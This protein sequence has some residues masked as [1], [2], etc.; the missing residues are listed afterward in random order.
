MLPLVVVN[1]A[2][3]ASPDVKIGLVPFSEYVY[4]DISTT[5]IRGVHPDKHGNTVTACLNNRR[6]PYTNED[7]TPFPYI[8]DSKWSAPGMESFWTTSGAIK[9]NASVNGQVVDCADLV[10]TE[11]AKCDTTESAAKDQCDI[12]EKA[13]KNDCEIRFSDKDDIEDCQDVAKAVANQCEDTAE[14]NEDQCVINARALKGLDQCIKPTQRSG[15]VKTEITQSDF[16]N[17]DVQCSIY[18]DRSIKVTPLTADRGVLIKQLQAMT[19]VK[20]TN[21]ALG[22][23]FGWHLVSSNEPYIDG[24]SYAAKDKKKIVVLLT[25]GKQTVG[26]YGPGN[27]FNIQKANENTASLCQSMKAKE[28]T[29]FTI[30]FDL[31]SQPQVK[32]MLRTCATSATHFMNAAQNNQLAT[33]FDCILAQLRVVRLTK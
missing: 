2:M 20:M 17:Q 22:L 33:V 25:D 6:R 30:A 5:F 13:E 18:R 29:V 21:I 31:S 8:D 4:T 3:D 27:S 16:A 9:G 7:S 12:T 1:K 28:I 23:E 10:K 24:A 14:A 32:K 15:K 11:K 26:G 19:P